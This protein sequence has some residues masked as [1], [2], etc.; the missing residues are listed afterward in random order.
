M[1]GLDSE[2]EQSAGPRGVRVRAAEAPPPEP[3]PDARR[4]LSRLPRRLL[5]ANESWTVL[6]LI[7]IMGYF[8]A[9]SPGRFLT[10]GDLSNIA[11]NAAP[12]LVMAVGQTFVIL[13]AG[14]DLSVGSVLVLA[15]VV[16]GEYYQHQA[17]SGTNA[18]WGVIALGALIAMAVG[19]AFGAVQGFVI[20]KAKVP[21]LITTLAGLMVAEGFSYL[22]TGGSD[23]RAVPT[24]LST[25]IGLGS[26]GGVPWLIVISFALALVF[27]LILAHTSFGRYTYAIGSNAEA[28][29][30]AGISV[31][32]HLIKVYA[33]QGLLAG[34]AGLLSLAYFGTT[35][36]SGHETD[37]LTVIT[38]VVLGGASLF[39]GRGTVF[40]SVVGVFIPAMLMTGLVILAVNQYW[41]YVAIGLVLGAAVYLDQFRRRLR[42]RS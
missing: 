30:R 31:D 34:V 11:A 38:A 7:L 2:P 42:E 28:A 35:T 33:L 29:R 6:A 15:G 9:S 22:M 3:G 20:A 37:N 39:G 41:Q 12:I 24:R 16:A 5:S 25:T 21:P 40:G 27:G 17:G 32:R 36:I 18:G 23:I 1:S 8:T 19:M 10:A 14:I 13:T 4:A 26:V